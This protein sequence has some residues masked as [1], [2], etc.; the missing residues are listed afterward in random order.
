MGVK[1]WYNHDTYGNVIAQKVQ[2]DN[3][4]LKMQTGTAYN[5][6]GNYAKPDGRAGQEREYR[7]ERERG[8]AAL[9]DGRERADDEL[10]RI[11]SKST[12]NGNL[13]RGTSNDYGMGNP[14][15]TKCTSTTT[16]RAARRWWPST[17]RT[18]RTCTICRKTPWDWLTAATT[19]W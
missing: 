7:A 15:L 6:D 4:T 10:G 9:C 13:M 18:I 2:A 17:G 5:S 14:T 16:R 19:S 11:V 1:K 8:R 3:G 12:R